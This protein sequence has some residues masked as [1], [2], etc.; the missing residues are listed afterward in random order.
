MRVPLRGFLQHPEDPS[1]CLIPLTKGQFA[2]VDK[3]DAE[4]LSQWN[5]Y[6]V[7]TPKSKCYF[8]VRDTWADKKKG[9]PVVMAR[10]IMNVPEGMLADHEDH[11]E[12]NNR[13]S[14]LR[15]ATYTQNACNNRIR[16]NNKSGVKGVCWDSRARHKHWRA[17]VTVDKKTVSLGNFA[18][19]E[20]ASAAYREAAQRLHGEFYCPG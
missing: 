20:E 17:T 9:K 16:K 15:L 12:L 1:A 5:W 18:T 14:N 11:N 19:I 13:R 10:A 7:W 8:A 2:V 4:W 6:A 3:E